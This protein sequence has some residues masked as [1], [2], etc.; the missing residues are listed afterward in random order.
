MIRYYKYN[1]RASVVTC[2]TYPFTTY[3]A[4]TP[5]GRMFWTENDL[6]WKEIR[7][8][9]FDVNSNYWEEIPRLTVLIRIPNP[10]GE[11]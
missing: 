11:L 3:L 7:G 6:P 1:Y 5:G 4:I 8:S 10:P 2:V 9:Q